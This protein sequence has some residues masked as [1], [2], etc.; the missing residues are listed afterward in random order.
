MYLTVKINSL[1]HYYQNLYAVIGVEKEEKKFKHNKQKE[2]KKKQKVPKK[3]RQ[4]S[5]NC[6]H[7][8]LFIIPKI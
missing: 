5:F 6:E 2:E 4:I 8:Y 3:R 7:Y 1:A